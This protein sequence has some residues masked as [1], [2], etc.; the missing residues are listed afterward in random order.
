MSVAGNLNYGP[1][2]TDSNLVLAAQAGSI[3]AFEQLQRQYS[4][5]IY[6]KILSITRNREDADDA[7][8]DAFLR[9]Y[10][11]LQSFEGRSEFKTWLMQ[12]GINSALMT[13]RKRRVQS[14]VFV[15]PT[16][17][18]DSETPSLD[19]RDSAL[20]PEQTYDQR[21]RLDSINRAVQKLEPKLRSALEIWISQGCSMKEISEALGISL[22]SV[23]ARL[24]RARRRLLKSPAL[25][26]RG[27]TVASGGTGALFFKLQNREEP[28]MNCE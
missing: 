18:P 9:A 25:R 4:P 3:P 7:L 10:T 13:I 28:C 21:Q 22:A 24:H 1:A 16:A 11:K 2:H 8:Q 19:F 27:L 20:D 17:L 12:I 23:K 5:H 15:E 14:R 6:R 26:K